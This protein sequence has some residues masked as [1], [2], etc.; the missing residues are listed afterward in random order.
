[1]KYE[2]F[3]ENPG[4]AKCSCSQS[5]PTPEFEFLEQGRQIKLSKVQR[6]QVISKHKEIGWM[7]QMQLGVRMWDSI[8][9]STINRKWS[10]AQVQGEKNP[11]DLLKKLKPPLIQEVTGGCTVLGSV[12]HACPAPFLLCL[13]P[14]AASARFFI[15]WTFR[16]STSGM[17]SKSWDAPWRHAQASAA[18]TLEI[19][20]HLQRSSRGRAMAV[21]CWGCRA[22]PC[23]ALTGMDLHRA[24]HQVPDCQL[25]KP[26]AIWNQPL[27][28]LNFFYS[29]S[30]FLGERTAR[31]QPWV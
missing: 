10:P 17:R 15:R 25:H 6:Q 1:M 12:L 26:Q 27:Q 22:A 30:T 13:Y 4:W 18:L 11:W 31:K 5:L 23:P 3:V 2:L 16:V 28:L 21:N 14:L 19:S 24:S 20:H 9:G 8:P 29:T 7:V